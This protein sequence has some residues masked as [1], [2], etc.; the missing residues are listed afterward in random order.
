MLCELAQRRI[1]DAHLVIRYYLAQ[2]QKHW[3]V[4]TIM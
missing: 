3:N 1:F 2:S 4:S